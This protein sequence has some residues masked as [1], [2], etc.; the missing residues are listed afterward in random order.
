MQ[1]T[2][3]APSQHPASVE[4]EAPSFSD[5]MEARQPKE[6]S[7]LREEQ[8]Q[9]RKAIKGEAAATESVDDDYQADD[10]PEF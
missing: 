1:Q 2:T 4:N 7:E 9:F 5:Y 6:K 3:T 10:I 8:L